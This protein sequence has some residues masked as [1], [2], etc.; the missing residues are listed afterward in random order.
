MRIGVLIVDDEP[1][2]LDMLED[3]LEEHFEVVRAG[4]V[5]QA[6]R[7]LLEEARIRLAILDARMPGGGGLGLL[8]A[9]RAAGRPLEA[10]LYSGEAHERLRAEAAALGARFV[11]KAEPLQVLVRTALELVRAATG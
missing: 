10:V 11:S 5:E 1:D 9:V 6:M 2:V 3:E 8:R 4:S 7:V